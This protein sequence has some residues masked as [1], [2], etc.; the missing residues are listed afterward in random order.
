MQVSKKTELECQ[1]QYI[2]SCGQYCN[3]EDYIYVTSV[4]KRKWEC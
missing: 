1:M 2:F 4:T 3:L